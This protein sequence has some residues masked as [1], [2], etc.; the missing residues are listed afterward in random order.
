[1][2]NYYCPGFAESQ[3]AYQVLF[4]LRDEYP[5]CFYPNVRIAKI[6]GNFPNMIWNGGSCWYG[7]NLDGPA[8]RRYFEWYSTKDVTLQLVCTNPILTEYDL[9]DRYCNAILKIASEYDFVEVLVSS[10]ILEEYIR[11]LYPH[12]KIDKSIIATTKQNNTELDTLENYLS[13]TEQY[14]KCVLPRKY[15]Q[16]LNFLKQIPEDKRDKFEILVTDP[17]PITCPRLYSHYESLAKGQMYIDEGCEDD[18]GCTMPFSESPFRN[19]TYR[20]YRYSYEQIV[21]N[22]EPL[23]FTEIKLSGRL[24]MITTIL[25]IVPYLIKPEYQRD[26]Y[27]GL[28]M[29]YNSSNLVNPKFI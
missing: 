19:Y 8:I 25:A 9:H 24:N 4:C 22:L 18:R 14:N 7:E 20:K 17:C 2:I 13:L 11:N 1:M 27:T 26:V 15:T 29:Y 5:E 21:E 10:P 23:G 28:F 16:D 12:M 6:Y 3:P